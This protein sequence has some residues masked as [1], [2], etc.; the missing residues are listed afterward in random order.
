MGRSPARA[1]VEEAADWYLRLRGELSQAEL[2][3]WDEWYADGANQRALES[4][5]QVSPGHGT[6]L[7]RPPPPDDAEVSADPYDGSVSVADW[8]ARQGK[9]LPA[10]TRT[11]VGGWHRSMLLFAVACGLAVVAFLLVS[12]GHRD[13]VEPLRVYA[14]A[15][16][17]H[18][19]VVLSDGSKVL[20]GA[21]TALTAQ[22]SARRRVVLL[23]PGEAFFQVAHNTHRPFIV[24]ASGAVI[25]AVGTQFNVRSDLNR[26]TVTVTEG[27]VDVAPS[28]ARPQDR[29]EPP[30][31]GHWVG[32]RLSQGQEL[33]YGA[34]LAR[35]VISK[36]DP[37]ATEWVSGRL[38]YRNLPLPNVV[39]DV[40]RYVNR[41]IT[42]DEGAAECEFTGTVDR[43]RVDDWLHALEKIFPL[44]VIQTDRAHVLI[45][46]R[47]GAEPHCGEG[48]R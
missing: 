29:P 41:E 32:A 3:E 44:E 36:A 22:F 5:W 38:Q 37:G 14:T 43:D 21:R 42:L 12:R 17:Q 30:N 18:E 23:G 1:R 24:V 8:L 13:T 6:L 4:I 45:R 7:D 25:T 11:G 2:R 10:T 9:K 46:S 26:V 47:P 39:A 20:L 34:E 15:V 27:A 35:A 19:T 33:T 31:P 16:G 48:V 28:Q 40:G